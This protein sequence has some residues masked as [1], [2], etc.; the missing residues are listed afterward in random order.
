MGGEGITAVGGEFGLLASVGTREV[1]V[2]QRP[3]IGVIST[4]DEIVQHNRPGEL[5]LGE[6]RDTNRPTLLT[7]IKGSG[8]KAVDLGIASDKPGALEQTLRDAMRTVDVI[9]TS[10]GVSMGE[11]DLLK[12]T[13]ERSLGGTIH[14]GRVSMKPGKPTTFATVP[15]KNNAGERVS[16]VIFSLPGN[17]VSAIVTLHLFVLPSLHHAAGVAPAG[18]PKVQVILDHEFRLDPQR[19]EYH[20]AIVSLGKDGSMHASSTG[21]QRSSR[22]GSL[23]S[24]NS[25]LCL[26]AGK[27]TLSKGSKIEALLMGRLKSE[28]DVL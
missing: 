18:L 27:E 17:P 8:F 19:S 14:F 13:I 12:P 26:P 7:A 1:S 15:V 25:L 22:V 24:A 5:Q 21:G 16:K 11:L 3:V 6:V 4:G 23:K 28:F 2:Y 9:I 20:R 10:G